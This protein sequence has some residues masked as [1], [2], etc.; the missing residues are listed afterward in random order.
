MKLSEPPDLTTNRRLVA[1]ALAIA[2]GVWV[3]LA[4]TEGR[5]ATSLGD[6][7]DAMRLVMARS[8]LHGTGW[9]D[10]LV[11]RLQ[12][13]QGVYMHWSR[14]L[15]G[16]L[17]VCIWVVDR[18]TTP[19]WSELVV[20]FAWPL[21]WIPLAVWAALAIARSL[22]GRLAV[23]CCALLLLS[24]TQLYVQFRPGR[25]DHHNVQITMAVVAVACAMAREHR[26]RFAALAGLASG[27]GLAIG[28]E[29][30]AF[31]ALA[32]ASFAI[33]AGADRKQA[34]AARAYGLA[35]A[36][37]ALCLFMLQ[38]PPWR[39][40]LPFCDQLGV[41]LVA[42]IV[43]A[44]L[45]LAG[46]ATWGIRPGAAWRFLQLG[47]IGG[48]AASLYFALDPSCIHGPFAAVDPRLRPIWFNRIS[49]LQPWERLWFQHRDSA[50]ITIFMS[51]MGAAAAVL[52]LLVRWRR[53]DRATLL[54]AALVLLA[55]AT[56]S[57]AWRME[58]YAFWYGVPTLAAAIGWLAERFWRGA[59]LPTAVASL[60]LS[61]V[62]LAV[63]ADAG[64]TTIGKAFPSHVQALAAKAKPGVNQS[65]FD[66]ALYRPLA[67]LPPGV[68]L[69]E[70]D[71]GP[72]VLAHTSDSVLAAPYHRMSWGILKGYEALG[73]PTALAHDRLT[74]LNVTYVLDCRL[75]PIRVN[76]T[77]FEGDLRKGRVPD[78]IQPLSA[79][80]DP[81][82]IFRVRP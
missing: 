53:S 36:G 19:E 25:I 79:P 78:W 22:G 29:A 73:G 65:C 41:N 44:G 81:M 11:T 16:A 28:I 57:R 2:V 3:V 37:G 35:L 50:L 26:V 82:Q 80:G 61:P 34:P 76:P 47:A 69:G 56:A 63:G 9:Y 72:H 64:L 75:N 14:L 18:F 68:V 52:L 45:G 59:M 38:T 62:P 74:A 48:A 17:A 12:P 46:F 77:G 20:R 32:G 33:S 71:L 60:A 10:Q 58:D 6:T 24:N 5:I 23:F 51:I 1:L 40:G 4:I 27:L 31:H 70:I 30:L 66:S 8:L 13:P 54:A 42:A 67:A 7:D 49:E 39:W 43:V 21:L 15:D 55:A